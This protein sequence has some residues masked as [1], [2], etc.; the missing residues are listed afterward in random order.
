MT[1]LTSYADT[2]PF[3]AT[4]ETEDFA[5]IAAKVAELGLVLERWATGI[6]L[7]GTASDNEVLAAY[8]DDIARIRARG[9][10]QSEDVV[11]LTPD[12]P[13]G[14]ALRA[15]F[16]AEH[17]HSDDEV[18]FFVE[19]SG[20][21]Y[22]RGQGEVHALECTAGDLIVLP[23]GTRHWFDTGPRPR[24]TAIRLFTTPEGWQ[25]DY[26]GDAI[27]AHIPQYDPVA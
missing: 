1:H 11:R 24:F 21:F 7:S 13:Q 27:A 9:G 4:G 23:A 8:A 20:L 18:R 17:V 10:Y 26:T 3:S 22:I 14:P 6:D 19:G 2:A 25:A 15:K 16:L 12:N 5:T